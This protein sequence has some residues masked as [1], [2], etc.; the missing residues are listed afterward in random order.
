MYG[1]GSPSCIIGTTGFAFTEGIEAVE[2][3]VGLD[4]KRPHAIVYGDAPH[5][6]EQDG[7]CFDAAGRL[8]RPT[9]S[10]RS[11]SNQAAPP[12]VSSRLKSAAERMRRSRQRRRNGIVAVIPVEIS[13]RDVSQ[14]LA[15]KLLTNDSSGNRAAIAQAIRRLL[16][17]ALS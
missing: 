5:S 4:F 14:L 17:S 8:I 15:R 6:Y 11:A 16:T 12:V 9:E 7:H 1:S 10:T 13:G 2:E 3:D